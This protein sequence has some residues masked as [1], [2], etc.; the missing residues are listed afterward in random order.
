M[1]DRRQR[2]REKGGCPGGKGL[3]LDGEETQVYKSTRELGVRMRNFML[4]GH[5]N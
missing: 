1:R 5:V 2:V 4:I 3:L